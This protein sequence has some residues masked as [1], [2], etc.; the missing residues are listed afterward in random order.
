MLCVRTYQGDNEVIRFVPGSGRRQGGVLHDMTRNRKWRS[1]VSAECRATLVAKVAYCHT[2]YRQWQKRVLEA[3]IRRVTS[4]Q[5]ALKVSS[6]VTMT[7]LNDHDENLLRFK[8]RLVS[9]SQFCLRI[10][11]NENTTSFYFVLFIVV[12]YTTVWDKIVD[13]F[14]IHLYITIDGTLGV[15]I[16]F[17]NWHNPLTQE[18]NVHAT[19]P[20]SRQI[21]L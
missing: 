7:N 15:R 3:A 4:L 17:L 8:L 6:S 2:A 20:V 19:V 9:A 11:G 16:L 13:S 14:N 18:H 10:I 12:S 21:W 1:L 5:A